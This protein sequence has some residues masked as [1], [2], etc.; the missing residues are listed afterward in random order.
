M[1]RNLPANPSIERLKN[2][3]QTLYK[4][5]AVGNADAIHRVK[6]NLTTFR[7]QADSEIATRLQLC[8]A[9]DV[10][11][12][13]YG[14]THWSALITFSTAE[15]SNHQALNEAMTDPRMKDLAFRCGLASSKGLPET[16]TQKISEHG[17]RYSVT[18]YA[19]ALSPR[20][21]QRIRKG[22]PANH[23][24]DLMPVIAFPEMSERLY[25]FYLETDCATARPLVFVD[26]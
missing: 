18:D 1:P 9:L 15:R 3:A 8:H 21:G 19:P 22:G 26:T 4:H 24:D 11:A 14:F 12:R 23:I 13:E 6:Q 25:E 16:G 7:F 17:M 20:G 2:E 5:C 10:I